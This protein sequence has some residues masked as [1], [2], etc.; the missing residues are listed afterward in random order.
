MNNYEFWE[1]YLKRIKKEIKKMCD[2]KDKLQVDLHIHSTYSADGKQTIKQI[3]E[4][5]QIDLSFDK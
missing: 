1:E 4:T 5:N 3:L 2:K